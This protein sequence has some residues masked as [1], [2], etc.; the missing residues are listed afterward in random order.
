[1]VVRINT[2]SL[3][4]SNIFSLITRVYFHF[5][6]KMPTFT[7]LYLLHLICQFKDDQRRK[8]CQSKEKY[9]LRGITDEEYCEVHP[10]PHIL[11]GH[12]ITLQRFSEVKDTRS[13]YVFASALSP[14]SLYAPSALP[15]FIYL[16]VAQQSVFGIITGFLKK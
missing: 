11:K 6:V 12:V 14:L 8:M 3:Q 13:K 16:S 1:M 9:L 2:P 5:D 15:A 4:V 7:A 10:M